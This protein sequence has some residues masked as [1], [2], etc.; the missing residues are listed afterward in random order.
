[1][2]VV[3]NAD[4][5]KLG[6]RGD[7][8]KV[9]N[10]YF[11]NFLWPRG[12]AS[13]ATEKVL[14][15]ALKRRENLVLKRQQLLDNAKEALKKLHGLVVTVKGKITKTGK[16][17]AGISAAKLIDAVEK[18]SKIKLEKDFLQMDHLKELGEHK[19]TVRLGEGLEEVI[20]VNI[21]AE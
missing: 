12:L 19:V 20:T 8:V 3:L 4:V 18:A 9:K 13:V 6:Y 5:Q 1:M 2:Q 14:Q 10:G 16:L 15:V 11:R 21:E 17:Y 7:V